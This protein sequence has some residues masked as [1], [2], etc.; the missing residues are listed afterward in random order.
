MEEAN[1]DFLK[2]LTPQ[3]VGELSRLINTLRN[4]SLR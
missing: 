1:A 2:A 3:E 4:Q